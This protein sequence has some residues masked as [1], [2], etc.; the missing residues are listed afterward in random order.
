[1]IFEIGIIGNTSAKLSK[2]KLAEKA[3][4][5]RNLA[6]KQAFSPLTTLAAE[7]TN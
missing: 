4:D 2:R 6:S 3:K 5:G 7:T 1:M